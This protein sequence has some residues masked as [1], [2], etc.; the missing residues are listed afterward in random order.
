M[1]L[2]DAGGFVAFFAGTI[3]PVYSELV[4]KS[5]NDLRVSLQTNFRCDTF[6]ANEDFLTLWTESIRHNANVEEANAHQR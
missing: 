1:L 5:F 4:A 6:S 2:H 3:A